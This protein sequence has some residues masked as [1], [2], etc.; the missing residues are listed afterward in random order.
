MKNTKNN[1]ARRKA[2][3]AAQAFQEK[4]NRLLALAED[5]FSIY[6]TSGAAAI[7]KKIEE[8]ETKI[9]QLR[10][11]LVTIIQGT[12]AEKSHIVARF[13]EEGISQQEISQRICLAPSEVRQLLKESPSQ[14]PHEIA[15]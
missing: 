14:E 3:E 10:K 6:E 12:E 1:T 4:E 11:E 9:Q 2:I 15:N 7:D 8:H 5:Y 13:K